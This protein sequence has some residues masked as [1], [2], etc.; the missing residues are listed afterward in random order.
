MWGGRH[1][2]YMTP[3]SESISKAMLKFNRRFSKD[4][5]WIPRIHSLVAEVLKGM[6]AVRQSCFRLLEDAND[7]VMVKT[8]ELLI[9]SYE[10]FF[11]KNKDDTICFIPTVYP[12]KCVWIYNVD[13]ISIHCLFVKWYDLT[14]INILNVF[15]FDQILK[16]INEYC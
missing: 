15:F 10:C 9:L 5:H 2:E 16:E 4:K 6:T 14:L 1:V 13:I 7:S 12:D 3:S 8:P 11:M